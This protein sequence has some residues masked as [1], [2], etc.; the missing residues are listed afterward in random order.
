MAKF[1][2][3]LGTGPHDP[4]KP[5]RCMMVAAAAKQKGHEVNIFLTDEAVVFGK[6]GMAQ[7]VVSMAGDEMKDY[8][9]VLLE[10][11]VPVYVCRP[12]AEVRQIKEEDLIGTARI[13]E[14]DTLVSLAVDSR[15]FNY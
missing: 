4:S 9:D 11:N 12:C 8:L 15:I 13:A 2:F 10:A 3:V 14:A 1:L 6:K 7:Y 5:T